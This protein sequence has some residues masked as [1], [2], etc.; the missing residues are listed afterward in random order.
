[1]YRKWPANIC[2]MGS[3]R[4]LTCTAL[5]VAAAATLAPASAGAV[6]PRLLDASLSQAGQRL[7][8]TVR[9]SEPVAIKRLERRPSGVASRSL[10]LELRRQGR[11]GSRRLCLG[12]EPHAHRRAGLELLNSGGE[13]ADAKTIAVRLKRPD[14]DELVLSLLPA[15]AGL[16]PHRYRWRVVVSS[17]CRRARRCEEDLPARGER[18]F[19]LR[20]VRAVGCTGGGAGLV[21]N[22]PRERKVVALTFDDG[23]SD[24]TPGFLDVLRREGVP[25]TF[26]EIGQEIGGREATMRRILREGDEIG[27]HTSHHTE[28]PGYADIS[29]TTSLIESATHFRPCLFRPPGGAVDSSVIAAA[30]ADGMRTVTWDVDPA[31]W[32]NPGGAAVYSRVVGAAR[33]GSIVLMHDG[34]GDRSGTLAALPGII[35]TLRA[36]GYRFATVTGLLGERML[37]RPYG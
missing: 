27:N 32:T 29:P 30:A 1:M 7:I 14:P 36:R 11:G 23:P 16:R 28:F 31:D 34:G 19:R 15:D 8:F 25:G 35:D 37:Y 10:C 33:P 12:G 20:P 24:Y 17:G 3:S 13:V 22:G 9:T 5:L 21:T 2:P 18:R 6:P 26:F 4:K